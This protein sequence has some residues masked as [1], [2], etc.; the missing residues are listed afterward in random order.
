MNPNLYA[1]LSYFIE[2]A[3]IILIAQQMN[4]RFCNESGMS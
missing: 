4:I 2:D 1:I 3:F